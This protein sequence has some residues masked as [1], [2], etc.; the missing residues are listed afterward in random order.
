M[1]DMAMVLVLLSYAAFILIDLFKPARK[2]E[3]VKGW[4][5]IGLASTFILIPLNIVVSE[6]AAGALKGHTLF[7]SS[8]LGEV[9]GA[10]ALFLTATFIAYWLHRLFH[11]VN[12]FWRWT[13][14]LHHSAERMDIFG[15]FFF[16]PN[17]ILLSSTLMASVI[18][19]LGVTP[20]AAG[21]AGAISTFYA[22]FQHANINT[23]AW[24]G[25]VIQ[26]PESH[27]IHHQRGV[28]AFN[29]GDFPMWDVLF[30]TFKNPQRHEAPAGF[31]LGSSKRIFS[32]LIGRDVG[33]PA[34][35][36]GSA[37]EPELMRRAA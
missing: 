35:E 12:F 2:Y 8:G 30:G 17:E 16:H 22:L 3:P 20:E 7:D 25:Y 29:Y 32:M 1:A 9:G 37:P 10:V 6:L 13:H 23:P 5:L 15:A 24:L 11:R 33:T 36:T 14:Q 4:R 21:L 19:L 18:A 28:H 26:R 34:M 31:Y 27:G